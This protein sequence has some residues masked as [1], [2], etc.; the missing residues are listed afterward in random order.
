MLGMA[1]VVALKVAEVADA[2]TVTEAGV[3]R[4]GLVLERVTSAPPAGA[5]FVS[6]TVQMLDELD[7]RLEGLHAREETN[8]GATRLT[9]VFAELLL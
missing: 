6:V 1:V 3:E 4:V 8:A 2:A 5:A 7:P 9:V